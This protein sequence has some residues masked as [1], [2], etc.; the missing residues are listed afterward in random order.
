[1]R[2]TVRPENAVDAP[3]I[4]EVILRAFQSLSYSDHTEQ[5]MVDR[6]RASNAYLPPLAMVAEIAN[7][8]VGHIM[9]TRV[10]IRDGET[11]FASLALAPLSVLPEFQNRGVG[12][13]LVKEAHKR[14]LHLGFSSVI[15]L[16]T[17]H[18]YS[19]FGYV[20]L[21]SC[22]IRVPFEIRE[23]NC[24]ITPLTVDGLS[25]VRGVVEYPSE[26]TER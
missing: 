23:E 14:A 25:G 13:A 21:S 18:Y 4:A 5:V 19:Q 22:N 26:W 2:I 11:S 7:Q 9:L 6:L 20:P 10:A 15:V 8:I 3:A 12:T 1:M 16:G 17:P 24:M